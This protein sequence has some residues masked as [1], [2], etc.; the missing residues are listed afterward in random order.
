[1]AFIYGIMHV[2][3][4]LRFFMFYKQT[5]TNS[6]RGIQPPFYFIKMIKMKIIFL[7]FFLVVSCLIYSQEHL[8]GKKVDTSLLF[9]S[10]YDKEF[11]IRSLKPNAFYVLCFDSDFNDFS[12]ES[13][14][15]LERLGKNVGI[16]II[17]RN[18][19]S[20]SSV[21][22]F[23]K[24][25]LS[26]LIDFKKY[27]KSYFKLKKFPSFFILDNDFRILKFIKSADDVMLNFNKY[28]FNYNNLNIEP[29]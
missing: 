26:F 7:L 27:S 16:I 11:K 13:I 9:K 10:L 21:Q 5:G 12:K 28:Y 25:N 23:E 24:Q 3:N 2:V 14:Q 18:D 17:S 15:K 20:F 29:K 6:L 8:I 22:D 4:G 1:M 19:N